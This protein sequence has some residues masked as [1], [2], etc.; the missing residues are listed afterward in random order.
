MFC[1]RSSSH[2]HHH[3]HPHH[4]DKSSST[5]MKNMVVLGS[6]GTLRKGIRLFFCLFNVFQDTDHDC[7]RLALLEN[8]TLGVRFVPSGKRT[9]CFPPS[10]LVLIGPIKTGPT[11]R[12]QFKEKYKHS[13][14]L[15]VDC[16]Q[17]CKKIPVEIVEHF[18]ESCRI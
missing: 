11:K 14:P 4:V 7:S 2:R 17:Q 9:I 6:V 15:G 8:L 12:G 10:A 16:D 3:P 5:R 18:V 1:H 13:T